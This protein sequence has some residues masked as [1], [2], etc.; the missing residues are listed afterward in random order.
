MALTGLP[1]RGWACDFSSIRERERNPDGTTTVTETLTVSATVQKKTTYPQ[2]W[3]RWGFDGQFE[4]GMT[5]C[6]E[7]LI[8]A[9]GGK[10]CVKLEQQV[11]VTETGYELLSHAPLGLRPDY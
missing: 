2:D 4:A 5:V 3:R 7:A 11:L 6:I 9:A 8:G 10:E 1:V